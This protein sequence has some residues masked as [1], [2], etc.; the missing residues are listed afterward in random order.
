MSKL[1]HPIIAATLLANHVATVKTQRGWLAALPQT[2]GSDRHIDC[3]TYLMNV[4]TM[5]LDMGWY[6]TRENIWALS[7]QNFDKALEYFHK[8]VDLEKRM[9]TEESNKIRKGQSNSGLLHYNIARCYQAKREYD[10]AISQGK[11]ALDIFRKNYD[12]HPDIADTVY[13]IGRFYHDKKD[14][15]AARKLYMESLELNKDLGT[16]LFFLSNRR[17][18]FEWGRLKEAILTLCDDTKEDFQRKFDVIINYTFE[19]EGKKKDLGTI[20]S[21]KAE[22]NATYKGHQGMAVLLHRTV[23][24]EHSETTVQRDHRTA[25]PPYSDT[26]VHDITVQRDHR[27]VRPPYSDITVQRDHRTLRPPHSETTVQ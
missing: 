4:G 9:K 7:S 25:S 6:Y 11:Q 13:L 22:G 1:H 12:R 5:Y 17:V 19:I 21:I 8:A 27:T 3:P 14:Y 2:T 20:T 24:S 26:T 18:D 10:N 15:E 16:I 23:R